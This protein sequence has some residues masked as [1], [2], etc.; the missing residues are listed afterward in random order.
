MAESVVK[1]NIVKIELDSGNIRR[2]W[3]NHSIGLSDNLGDAFGVEL[4]RAGVPVNLGGATIMGYFHDPWGDNIVINGG[5]ITYNLAVI[6]LPQACYNH[7]GQFTLA[8]KIITDRE[9]SSMVIF[10]GMI[11]NT[12]TGSAVAPTGTVPTYQEVLA[13]YD[14]M[15]EAKAGSVRFDIV[16]SLTDAQKLQA[17]NNMGAYYQPQIDTVNGKIGNTVL[18]TTAQ[19]LTGAIAEHDGDLTNQQ[20]Q[21]TDL[22]SAISDNTGTE[23]IAI[24]ETGKYIQMTGATAV[25]KT[26]ANFKYSKVACQPGDVF[27]VSAEG[28]GGARC[29]GWLDSNNGVISKATEGATVTNEIMIAPE[30]SAYLVIN[31]K[32]TNNRVSYKGELIKHITDMALIYNSNPSTN[33]LN[34]YVKPGYYIL[35]SSTTYTNSPLED[36]STFTGSR[37]LEVMP[38]FVEGS[39][40]LVQILWALSSTYAGNIYARRRTG[41]PSQQS[42]T[43]WTKINSMKEQEMIKEQ[44]EGFRTLET[45]DVNDATDTGYYILVSSTD[46]V[47]LPEE[48]R[49]LP[50]G[51]TASGAKTLEVMPSFS[52]GS[53]YLVQILWIL[54]S[55]YAGN[56]YARRRTGSAENPTWTDW[57]KVSSIKD[58]QTAL[59]FLN[60]TELQ[61]Y[62]P[63]S[64][65]SQGN[66]VGAKIR[67]MSYNICH[68]NN[69]TS[70]Y[71]S[72]EKLGNLHKMFMEVNADFICLQEDDRH[73]DS[74]ETKL[75]KSYLY[76]PVYPISVVDDVYPDNDM[77]GVNIRS[78]QGFVSRDSL[79]FSNTNHRALRYGVYEIDGKTLLLISAHP[80]LTEEE[81]AEEYEKLFKW[82]NGEITLN[83]YYTS[84]PVSVPTFTHCVIGMDA[85]SATAEDRANLSA[86]AEET[87]YIM[88]N[89]GV[90]GWINTSLRSNLPLDNI[91]VSPNVIINNIQ[92]L[93]GWYDLLYSD[94]VPVYCDLTL[95]DGTP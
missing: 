84:T 3:I 51:P 15:L 29:W 56:I 30:N 19:T 82:I 23:I 62:E 13:V 12:N 38:S 61:N 58:M 43:D 42:W 37:I 53:V 85:N 69:D 1:R 90:L 76:Y 24:D 55:T 86:E 10:D 77:A 91:I 40:F 94:H 59:Q 95:L 64:R 74:A 47:N 25:V 11:D 41:T 75:S 67:V 89:G 20:G 36:G 8:L 44:Y 32:V 18:P 21:I 79:E 70:T 66:N 28:A 6:Y 33:D 93:S 80:G 2:S 68:F 16:Q 78:K 72:A 73:I 50:N 39:A 14:Q 52:S 7:E 26:S 48:I 46:Y 35:G 57:I 92:V 88:A 4:Y 54:S 9:T 63:V 31:N 17:Q 49:P 83:R 34:D 71:I 81:R 60:N 5:D 87:G 45:T 22:K 65:N 27:T